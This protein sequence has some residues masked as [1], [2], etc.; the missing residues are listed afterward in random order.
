MAVDGGCRLEFISTATSGVGSTGERIGTAVV[1][2]R[3]DT[4]GLVGWGR[5]PAGPYNFEFSRTR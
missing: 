4:W 3:G 1:L 5:S 2:D